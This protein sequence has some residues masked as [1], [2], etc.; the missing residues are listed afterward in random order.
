[1]VVSASASPGARHVIAV[2][3]ANGPMSQPRG[4]IFLRYATLAFE[5][6]G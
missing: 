3:A 4:A 6:R 5:T 2:M 1:V